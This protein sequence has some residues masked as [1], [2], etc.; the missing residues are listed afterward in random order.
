MQIQAIANCKP[1]LTI[2]DTN[3]H[4]HDRKEDEKVQILSLEE[5]YTISGI[6][7]V[8]PVSGKDKFEMPCRF[9]G[10][11]SRPALPAVSKT[12]LNQPSKHKLQ[13]QQ[14]SAGSTE[15]LLESGR[16]PV[17]ASMPNHHIHPSF[18]TSWVSEIAASIPPSIAVAGKEPSD[19]ATK[20]NVTLKAPSPIVHPRS[21]SDES[22]VPV[23]IVG[24]GDAEIDNYETSNASAKAWDLPS[25]S[26]VPSPTYPMVR[27]F[28]A[29]KKF[30][31][32][33]QIGFC[34]SV[35]SSTHSPACTWSSIWSPDTHRCEAIFCEKSIG[36]MC[37]SRAF[38]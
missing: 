11:P 31:G 24:W 27:L 2:K 5:Y 26:R 35:S 22:T 12:F 16:H 8:Y 3:R 14:L 21:V 37:Y 7:R 15:P 17:D 9:C 23:K 25:K 20:R 4:G 13:S 32:S 30:E 6:S 10:S 36:S 28:H 1:N 38:Q 19:E 18:N 33:A 34:L 29:S